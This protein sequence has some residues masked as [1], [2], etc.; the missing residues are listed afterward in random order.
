MKLF[1]II[2]AL[3]F[4]VLASNIILAPQVAQAQSTHHSRLNTQIDY[5]A[6]VDHAI[7]RIRVP[8]LTQLNNVFS[9]RNKINY[10]YLVCQ[11]LDEGATLKELESMVTKNNYM[12]SSVTYFVVLETAAIHHLCPKY[13]HL[14]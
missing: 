5:L 10:G 4:L 14:L 6:A 1:P 8:E 12:D 13:Q 11:A 3:G 7:S 2:K 9:A